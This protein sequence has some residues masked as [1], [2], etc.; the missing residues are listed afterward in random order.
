MKKNFSKQKR[1]NRRGRGYENGIVKQGPDYR[2]RPSLTQ[3]V[4]NLGS[5]MP[6]RLKIKL[7]Y[8]ANLRL[9]SNTAQAGYYFAGN[10]PY[11]PDI[12]LGGQSALDYQ[13]LSNF[14]RYSRVYG[15]RITIDG[16]ILNNN[17]FKFAIGPQREVDSLTFDRLASDKRT[18]TSKY[19]SVGGITT[20]RKQNACETRAVWGVDSIDFDA[21]HGYDTDH[22]VSPGSL[23]ATKPTYEWYWMIFAQAA[24]PLTSINCS[25]AVTI[26]YD[27][28]FFSK[29]FLPTLQAVD[30]DNDIDIDVPDMID[31]PGIDEVQNV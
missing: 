15:S 5:G 8:H 21:D 10:T 12:K 9:E 29:Q 11:D 28:M 3:S 1:N 24:F 4:V 2:M 20:D 18:V 7:K 14:Y 31:N 22:G 13:L 30:I 23:T 17:I 27:C 26:E 16:V 19:L 6:D 25:F